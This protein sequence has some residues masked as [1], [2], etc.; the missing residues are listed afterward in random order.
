MLVQTDH[1]NLC[2][3]GTSHFFN[4]THTHTHIHGDIYTLSVR[5]GRISNYVNRYG[6][7]RK[8]RLPRR[9]ESRERCVY[10]VGSFN[11]PAINFAFRAKF[12]FYEIVRL[13]L[14]SNA[15][16]RYDNGIQF[17]D[18]NYSNSTCYC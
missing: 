8:R 4:G 10:A 9:T 5:Q 14:R 7:S 15:V 16:I 17:G 3:N 13:V 1:L 11:R 6:F 12:K 18:H 2:Q